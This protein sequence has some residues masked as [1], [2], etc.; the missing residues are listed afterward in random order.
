[1][2]TGAT[3]CFYAY[4]DAVGRGHGHA[5]EAES[6]E[7]A[8]VAYVE[9]WSPP[10]GGGNEIRVFVQ[11]P[12]EGVEHCFTLDLGDDGEPEPCD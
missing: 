12:D 10:V 7:A 2:N 11:D 4:A 9:A 1:M 6:A 5:I 8:A 3:H